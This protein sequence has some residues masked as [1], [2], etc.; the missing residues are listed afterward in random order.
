MGRGDCIDVLDNRNSDRN[1]MLFVGRRGVQNNIFIKGDVIYVADGVDNRIL[2]LTTKEG[3]RLQTFE[4]FGCKGLLK[5]GHD[6]FNGPVSV[7]VDH[8]DRMIVADYGNHRVVILDQNGS[9]LLTINGSD[10]GFQYPNC[11]ALDSQGNIHVGSDS[12]TIKVFTPDGVYVKSYGEVH[13]P[14]GIAVDKEGFIFV[15]ESNS[16]SIFNPQGSMVHS[17]KHPEG[18]QPCGLVLDSDGDLY[19]AYAKTVLQW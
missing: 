1:R 16:V 7:I 4:Q 11:F 13:C 9:W 17:I 8:R 10:Q 18:C 5:L 12:T 19:V 2:K 14:K 15:C 3:K 6:H